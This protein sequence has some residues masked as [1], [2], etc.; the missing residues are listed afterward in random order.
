MISLRGVRRLRAVVNRLRERRYKLQQEIRDLE[1]LR[2]KAKEEE[3]EAWEC[4][5]AADKALT[6]KQRIIKDVDCDIVKMVGKAFNIAADRLVDA[7]DGEARYH[8]LRRFP[9][10]E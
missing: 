2:R 9:R 6:L 5:F 8:K 7:K 10:E 4:V 3:A 1:Q